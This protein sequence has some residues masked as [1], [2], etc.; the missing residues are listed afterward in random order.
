MLN[1][2]IS[3]KCTKTCKHQGKI[4]STGNSTL[5]HATCSCL[6]ADCQVYVPKLGMYAL[7]HCEDKEPIL[8][9]IKVQKDS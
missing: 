1:K 7:I 6:L 9:F 5:F 4:D 8:P 2:N 3:W